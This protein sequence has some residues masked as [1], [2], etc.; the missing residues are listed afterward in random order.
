[1]TS[2]MLKPAPGTAAR[3][4]TA[5]P[6]S[7]TRADAATAVAESSRRAIDAAADVIDRIVSTSSETH[8]ERARQSG[9]E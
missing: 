7:V 3:N 4:G 1:M 6:R 5:N 8:L 9:G 2:T